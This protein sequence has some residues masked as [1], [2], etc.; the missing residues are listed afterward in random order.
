[1]VGPAVN[2]FQADMNKRLPYDP[3]GGQEAAG[4]GRLP[5]RLRGRR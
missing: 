3:E 1:M 4:R 5:E 2:G